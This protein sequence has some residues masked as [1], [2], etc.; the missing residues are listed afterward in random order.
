MY[1]ILYSSCGY[2]ITRINKLLHYLR[3]TTYKKIALEQS[4]YMVMQRLIKPYSRLKMFTY[5]FYRFL[6]HIISNKKFLKI[7]RIHTHNGE[8]PYRY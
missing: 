7:K 3:H 5:S 8:R 2:K 1:I 6:T 4:H